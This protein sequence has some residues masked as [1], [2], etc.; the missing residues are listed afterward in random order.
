MPAP[1]APSRDAGDRIKA[2]ISATGIGARGTAGSRFASSGFLVVVPR[3]RKERPNESDAPTAVPT[4]LDDSAA[5]TTLP[6][7]QPTPTG[8]WRAEAHSAGLGSQGPRGTRRRARAPKKPK[9]TP[10]EKKKLSK[11]LKVPLLDGEVPQGPQTGRAGDRGEATA[12]PSQL[13][14][15]PRGDERAPLSRK[16]RRSRL[17]PSAAVLGR[18]GHDDGPSR[19]RCERAGPLVQTI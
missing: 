4:G 18:W 11:R 9:P 3:G 8:V 12:R 6:G 19:G 13:G 5:T 17:R 14:F 2:A 16:Q 7:A 1:I 10:T 15:P